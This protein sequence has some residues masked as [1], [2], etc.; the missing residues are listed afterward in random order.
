MAFEE[1]APSGVPEWVVTYGDMMSLLL[2]FFIMLVS[3]SSLKEEGTMRAMLDAI[4]QK[5]GAT[6]GEF[7]TPG[8]SRQRSSIFNKLSSLGNNSR[9]GTDAGN[10]DSSGRNG[11]QKTVD[12]ITD[13]AV[14]TLGGPALFSEFEAELT[15]EIRRALDAIVEIVRDRPNH[16]EVRGHASPEPLPAGSPYADAWD[17]SFTRARRVADYLIERGIEPHRVIVSAAGS[18]EPRGSPDKPENLKLHHRVDVYL[19]DSYIP[20]E[21]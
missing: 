21:T 17:L 13:G 9:G 12:S 4:S 14:V 7:G 19:M 20:P 10:P 5:F 16:I 8:T 6:M 18:T 11:P 1:S 15:P 3:M 2:T